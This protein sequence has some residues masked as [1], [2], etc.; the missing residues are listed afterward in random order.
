[1]QFYTLCRRSVYYQP[2]QTMPAG[3]TPVKYNPAMSRT[4]SMLI[5]MKLITLLMLAACLQISAAGYSQNISL[6][7]KQVSLESVFKNIEKQTNYNFFY[8]LELLSNLNKVS[9]DVKN[10]PV[11]DVLDMVLKN[12]PVTYKIVDNIIVINAINASAAQN[13]KPI[14]VTGTVKDSK[15]AALPGVTITIKDGKSSAVTDGNGF[16]KIIVEEQAVLQ[17]TSVGY[18]RQEIPVNGRTVLAIALDDDVSQLNQV[19]VIGY[20]KQSR[21]KITDAITT[22]KGTELNRYSGASFA[23]QLAGKAAGVVINDASAQPGTDPQIVI[24]GIGTLT[25]GRAPLIVVDGFPL[26]EGSSF[27]S[28]NPQDIETL[29]ILKDP[30]SAAI[31]GSRAANG[32]IL[33]TTKKGSGDK[34]KVSLDV[35]AGF[36]ERRDNMKYVDAYQ[37]ATYFTEARDWGY[38]SKDPNNRSI[39]DDRAA[40]VAKGASLREL[41]LNYLQPYLDGKQGLTNTNWLDEV[42]RKAPM[43]SYNL[44]VSGS[45][46]KT[47]YYISSNYFKQD[48]IVINNGLERYSGTIKVESKISKMFTYGV[49]VNPSFNKEK[50]FN[51]NAN[52]SNDV[53]SD[54][55]ISY[56][57]FPAYNADG[58][59]AISQQIKGNT[60][61]DGALGESPIAL[62]TKIKNNLN[63][64]RLFGNTYLVFE[65]ITGLKFK[66]VLGTDIRSNFYDYYRPSDVGGYRAAAPQ[67]ASAIETNGHIYNY[68][69]ENTVDYSKSIGRHDFDIL[70]GYTFQSENGAN[71]A[72]TGS[73]IPDDNITNIAGASA[74]SVVSSRY[75]WTQISYLARLQYAYADKYL[76]SATI[77]RDGSSRF[78]DNNKWGNFPSV[79]AGYI[80]SKESFFPENKIL[81]FAKIR[82][83]WG[84]AGNN[85]IGSYSSKAL[86]GSAS[87]NGNVNEYNYNYVFGSTLSPGFAATTTANSNLTWETKNSTDIGIDL[88]FF[89]KFNFVADYYKSTTK[90]LL[91]NVPI[92]EQSGFINSIQN[93][94][95]VSNHGF[96]FELSGNNLN[97]GPFRIG[98]N[99][100][101]ATNVNRVLA[102]AP[103]QTQIIQGAS[104]NF[105]TKVGGPV[106]AM[107]GYNVIGIYKTQDAI[108]SSPHLAGTLTGDYKV[109]D[110]NHD[111]IIDTRDQ[112]SYGTY[113]PKFTY[114]FGANIA[115]KRFEL[116]VAFNGVYGRKIYDYGLATLDDSGEGFSMP[117][118]YY[119]QNRYHPVD[120]PT[121]TYA[122]PN[123][124]NLSSAR[125]LT[126]AASIFY[127]NGDYLRLRNAQLAYNL[128]DALTSK[129]KI[130]HIRLYCSAN[131]L[132]TWT[133]FRGYNPDATSGNVLTDGLSNANYPVARSFIF[134]ANVTF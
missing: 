77:R 124:G 86:I 64:T 69:T 81:T 8:K 30:A 111:G 67:P 1:M 2:V 47:N 70:A 130:S 134:G 51:N 43:S 54:V 36:Q 108:N 71:T 114:G 104:S 6:S 50:Y 88:A 101:L 60:P 11:T 49:S 66:T 52:N 25:A 63:D 92:P 57:F 34:V 21:E 78:G 26:S 29:D 94:G 22:V 84:S 117:S 59:V 128:P 12:Q 106:A 5:R 120:N 93:I 97:A 3:A 99:A 28:I 76:L 45:S 56:P 115:Y 125:R 121:G 90:N 48:G 62:A 75:Q 85:Q 38:V 40:R 110:T 23:Q 73:G 9:I 10:A 31:Y 80:L 72:V 19:V 119:F 132:F 18:K 131:N 79:T 116:N 35:Y 4:Q 44:S 68:I 74:F 133:K 42:F 41:R 126:R 118:L 107:Y 100:N 127:Y 123:L 83:S 17:I 39:N 122:Q 95:K 65:P 27:N 14:T 113:S 112:V 16:F 61:E 96:E 7:Q 109:A 102:L 55:T 98:F 105:I 87:N 13:L 24:R 15:G 129:V 46:G 33:I 20:G 53:V 91:L 58:S 103:G 82:A 32:V 89:Q 37:A